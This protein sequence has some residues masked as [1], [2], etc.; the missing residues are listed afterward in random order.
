MM[1][2]DEKLDPR[3]A[4]VPPGEYRRPHLQ[5]KRVLAKGRNFFHFF[6]S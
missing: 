1:V 4:R 5:P 3:K 2:G 6:R